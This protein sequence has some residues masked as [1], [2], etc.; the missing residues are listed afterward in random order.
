MHAWSFSQRDKYLDAKM[1]RCVSVIWLVINHQY[2]YRN[3][4]N[5]DRATQN[6]N[7]PTSCGETRSGNKI[8]KQK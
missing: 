3:I 2:E 8:L 6:R 1:C 4:K 5:N 7:E